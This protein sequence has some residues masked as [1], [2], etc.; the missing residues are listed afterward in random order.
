MSSSLLAAA[1]SIAIAAGEVIV[2]H[3]ASRLSATSKADA[4]PVTAADRAANDAI[5]SALDALTPGVPVVSEEHGASHALQDADVFWLV[6]PLDGTREF[7]KGTGEF[8]VNIALVEQGVPTMGVVHVPA[9]QVTYYAARRAAAFRSEG[10]RSEQ[11]GVHRPVRRDGLRVVASRDHAGPAVQELLATLPNASTLSMGS[12]LKF[13]LVA[14]GRA[15]VY[16]R[17]VPTMEWDTAAA[18]CVVAAAGGEVLTFPGLD[19]LSYGKPA[20][21]NPSIVT[22]G[23]TSASWVEILA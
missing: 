7:I 12:S 11:I 10:D 17:D 1:R 13:C 16:V 2:E 22:V 18:H 21:R 20:Y 14:E 9:L 3:Y 5:C 6:D 8:T 4:S 19:P 15:D 23:D